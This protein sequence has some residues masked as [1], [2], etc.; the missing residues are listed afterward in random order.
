LA[1]IAPE[2]EGIQNAIKWVSSSLQENANQ[3]ISKL[4]EKAAL[5]FD[6]SPMDSEFL[7]NFFRKKT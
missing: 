5:K 3:P 7:F 2:G 4:V 1:T 6:L